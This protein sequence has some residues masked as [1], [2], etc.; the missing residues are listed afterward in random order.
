LKSIKTSLDSIIKT[1]YDFFI[2]SF[3]HGGDVMSKTVNMT[4]RVPEELHR[5]MKILSAVKNQSMSEL[6]IEW[7]QKQKVSIPEFEVEKPKRKTVKTSKPKSGKAVK[8][9]DENPDADE[10]LIKAEI[11]KHKENGL[12]LQMIADALQADGIETIRGGDW[13][14]G[15]VDGL[16]KKWAAQDTPG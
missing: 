9:K 11:L 14:K 12:S 16:I 15:T 1:G 2:L 13:Q 8:R 5:K 4:L 10:E 7:L 6:F 3:Y